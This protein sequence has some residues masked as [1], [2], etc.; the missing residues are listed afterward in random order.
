M[1]QSIWKIILSLQ[2]PVQPLWFAGENFLQVHPWAEA[3]MVVMRKEDF[4]VILPQLSNF[5]S[6]E[7]C[8]APSLEILRIN[9]H[10]QSIQS[11]NQKCDN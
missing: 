1:D 3:W 5:L 8:L 7:V 11:I 9:S 2:V 6:T 4:S 10:M